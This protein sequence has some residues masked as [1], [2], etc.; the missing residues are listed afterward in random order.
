MDDNLQD[1]SQEA[2]RQKPLWPSLAADN[3]KAPFSYLD[4]LQMASKVRSCS[5][6]CFP[7]AMTTQLPVQGEELVYLWLGCCTEV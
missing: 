1:N 4:H 5:S 6:S 3:F 7:S 2:K